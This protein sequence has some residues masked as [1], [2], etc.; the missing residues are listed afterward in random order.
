MKFINNRGCLYLV[1]EHI[2]SLA[3]EYI[4]A[5]PID[6]N[7]SMNRY[8]RDSNEFHITIINP[9]E[10]KVIKSDMNLDLNMNLDIDDNEII[11]LGLG[12]VTNEISTAYYIVVEF[13]RGNQ[14]RESYGLNKIDFHITLGF[15][16]KD[17]HDKQKGISTLI[18][19]RI[20][21]DKINHMELNLS[22]I[23]QLEILMDKFNFDKQMNDVINTINLHKIDILFQ[24]K[25]YQQTIDLIN[26][27]DNLTTKLLYYRACAYKKLEQYQDAYI[28]VCE[29]L[30]YKLSNEQQSL[31]YTLK[32]ELLLQITRSI[33]ANEHQTLKL[34]HDLNVKLPRY[35]S[36]VIPGYLAASA[37]PKRNEQ[38][39]LFEL[40]NI[41][42]I[43]TLMIEEEIDHNQRDNITL[44]I[45]RFKVPNY[46]PPTLNEMIEIV[47]LMEE[48]MSNGKGILVH[49]G[50]KGRT[51]VAIACYLVKNGLS[52]IPNNNMNNNM[53]NNMTNITEPSMT[54]SEAINILRK[55][56]SKSLETP[57][58]EDFVKQYY[59]YLMKSIH[60]N[61]I[62]M[63][64]KPLTNTPKFIMLV[65]IPG[66]G[67]STFANKLRDHYYVISQDELG[68]RSEI[69]DQLAKYIKIGNVILDK[70]NV[71]K[72]ERLEWYKI[73]FEPQSFLVVY[74]DIDSD[75]CKK[76]V[77]NR[78]GHAT[79]QYGH[80]TNIVDSFAKKLE[81]IDPTETY[82]KDVVTIRSNTD[83][84]NLLKY[85]FKII[86]TDDVDSIIKF[87]RTPHLFNYGS[88][89]DDDLV[90]NDNVLKY[91]ISN[92][93]ITIEEKV[94]GSNMGIS[95]N[96]EYKFEI[97]NRS[98]IIKTN[99]HEQYSMVDMWVGDH[100]NDLIFILGDEPTRYILYG[101]WLQ[102]THTIHYEELVDYFIAFDIFD[103]FENKFL[104]R[105]RFNELMSQTGIKTV[106]TIYHG[107]IP[108]R[109]FL[110]KI[111]TY[112]SSLDSNKTI[113]G[114]YLRL[115]NDTS[116]LYRAKIVN[117]EFSQR[118]YTD[119]TWNT[120]LQFNKLINK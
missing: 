49:C 84:N 3:N 86:N 113:E 89:S 37:L 28:D 59:N 30:E 99:E 118:V 10:M 98:H 101:E 52:H 97:Q 80:G 54:P 46:E 25:M 106:N 102:A 83:L 48:S 20:T 81:P 85:R 88:I 41:N 76:R 53:T 71:R 104:S 8:N 75:I 105:K 120:K 4:N 69:E 72:D 77:M 57:Q 55:T 38:L 26:C 39:R 79:I 112:K 63:N 2:N 1:G 47:R 93:P 27:F 22:R 114:I 17:I 11:D 66:S 116:L 115:D 60:A 117:P 110:K 78:I 87:P 43:I 92:N 16:P 61:T 109:E 51:G 103:K 119:D 32:H 6:K 82:M 45:V 15:N 7:Y 42:R 94:D 62:G 44:D 33:D 91:F 100:Y 73:A 50:G 70:C 36:W 95:L 40:Y 18:S 90:L 111:L 35:T 68:N 21:K 12:S 23:Q 34:T 65:G 96:A 5:Y 64:I 108:N 9:N 13:K 56:R 19:H 24:Q 67:K 29:L 58:Q 31:L 74:F 107:I 14:L